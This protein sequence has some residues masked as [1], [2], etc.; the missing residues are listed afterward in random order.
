V[1]R[2][3]CLKSGLWRTGRTRKHVDRRLT[4]PP[5]LGAAIG[6][7]MSKR[8]VAPGVHRLPRRREPPPLPQARALCVR[9][10][11]SATAPLLA[12]RWYRADAAHRRRDH[13]VSR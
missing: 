10:S 4:M 2:L 13:R 11:P 5:A 7:V 1:E 8:P 6:W 3:R 12:P 9:C